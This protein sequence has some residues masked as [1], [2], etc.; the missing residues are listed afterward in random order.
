MNKRS[1]YI[2]IAKGLGILAV[3]WGHIIVG[4]WT[5]KLVY[6]FH[7]PLFFFI[8]GMLFVK[9]KYP[10][11]GPFVI[12][13]ARR[14][15]VPYICYFV[16]TWALW[17]L[18]HWVSH[19]PVDSYWAPLFQIVLAQGS[20]QFIVHNSPL[21]FIPCLFAVE[22]MYYPISKLKDLWA[23]V[24]SLSICGFSI[25]LEHSFGESYLFALPWNL[26]AAMMA[27]PFY[28]LGNLWM[29]H[30]TLENVDGWIHGHPW[31]S[32]GIV[33]IL[34]VG[35]VAA[36][37]HYPGIS[38]GYSAYGNEYIFHARALLGIGSTI[39]FSSFL[40]HAP[41]I[42]GL[43]AYL[44][45]LG[46]VSL[47]V[48]CTHVPIKGILLLTLAF[49]LKSSATAVGRNLYFALAVFVVTLLAVTVMVRWIDR[50][51]EQIRAKKI[52]E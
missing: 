20:G 31:L 5:G 44:S 46:R 13:R 9:E 38:M 4:H 10:K 47:D 17:A 51:R 15:L 28:A 11:F 36:T 45:W 2:D 16:I 3:I 27:L 39:V 8:S 7:M 19:S 24:L 32:L 41:F 22:M 40:A 33:L 49:A 12:V 35:L 21:W 52:N 34:T 1:E 43:R 26:D 50:G 23:L 30:T 14:L 48:M 29:R 6:S 18:F 25:A 42:R 37:F